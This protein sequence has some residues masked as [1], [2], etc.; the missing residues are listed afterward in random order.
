MTLFLLFSFFFFFFNDTATTEIYTAQYTLSLHDAL[1][2]CAGRRS[3]QPRGAASRG[4]CPSA[5]SAVIATVLPRY[6]RAPSGARIGIPTERIWLRNVPS[7]S[8]RAWASLASSPARDPASA[9]T[10]G[11]SRAQRWDSNSSLVSRGG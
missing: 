3:T 1:P 9:R 4:S 2:N 7:R 6:S 5:A 11:R 8:T 10:L